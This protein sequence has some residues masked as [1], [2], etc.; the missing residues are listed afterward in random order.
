MH[1]STESFICA[2]LKHPAWKTLLSSVRWGGNFYKRKA[3]CWNSFLISRSKTMH[4]PSFLFLTAASVRPKYQKLTPSSHCCLTTALSYMHA[5]TA[6]FCLHC[7]LTHRQVSRS[8]RWNSKT[9]PLI[10]SKW[11]R[12]FVHHT[13]QICSRKVTGRREA[14]RMTMH[15]YHTYNWYLHQ[16]PNSAPENV[17]SLWHCSRLLQ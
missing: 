5:A 16:L 14:V 8:Q 17:V 4:I 1:S 15:R 9:L 13:V 10:A 11:F 3:T 7:S 6:G 2:K 12:S